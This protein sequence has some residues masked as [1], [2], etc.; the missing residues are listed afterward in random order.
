MDQAA[1]IDLFV[2]PTMYGLDPH[3]CQEAGARVHPP[4]RRGDIARFVADREP[5]T[6]A[7]VDG[8]FHGY[9]AVGHRELR[10]AIEAGWNLWG[11][12][13]MG[14]I[15]AYELRSLGMRGF[16]LVYQQFLDHD[17]FTDD[18][19]ALMH[20]AAPPY[21]PLTEPLVNIREFLRAATAAGRLRAQAS[22]HI[23]TWLA[24]RWFGE[25]TLEQ[26]ERLLHPHWNAGPADLGR[27]MSQ[28][29]AHRLKRLDLQAFLAQRPWLRADAVLDPYGPMLPNRA[30]RLGAR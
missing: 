29:D 16:G 20:Q 7:I 14:A 11:L 22:A 17:D 30:M 4:V 15:R 23:A 9:P 24:E 5:G 18:E 28:F 13:S 3:V 2:G 12:S 27:W 10:E 26:L 8:T 25:R 19:V 21:R 6:L 1:G